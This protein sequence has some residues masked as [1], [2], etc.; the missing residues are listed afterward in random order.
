LPDEQALL[1]LLH[2]ERQADAAQ[3]PRTGVSQDWEQLLSSAFIRSPDYG[4][5]CSTVLLMDRRGQVSLTECTWDAAGTLVGQVKFNFE[6]D[7]AV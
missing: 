4:T 5:R 2:D 7:Q 3:L 1:E 6:R